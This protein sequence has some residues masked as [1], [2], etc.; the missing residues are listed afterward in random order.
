MG[1]FAV[2]GIRF[3]LAALAISAWAAATGRS[4]RLKPGQLGPL[5]VLSIIFPLQLSLFYLGISKTNASRACLIVNL[6]PFWV[7]FLS[8]LF[9]P[10]DRLNRRKFIGILMGFMGVIFLFI[11]KKGLSAEFQTGD[12]VVLAATLLWAA[13]V[14]Y[15][16]R[17]IAAY[18]PFQLVLYPMI[19]SVPIFLAASRLFDPATAGR[20]TAQW[21]GAIVYQSLITAAFGFVAWS[22]LMQTYGATAM[23]SFVFIM[24]VAGVSLAYLILGEPLTA[25]LLG[26]AACITAG[27]LIV[28]VK[29]GRITAYFLLGRGP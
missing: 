9:I 24:P 25:H 28:H 12:L 10:G 7:L 17:I 8:H 3:A 16:K 1:P 13:N 29:A 26:A 4:F 20:I 2:A 22:T 6:L 15:T 21:I 27:I 18:R 5:A 19:F 23:H 11:E 14:V